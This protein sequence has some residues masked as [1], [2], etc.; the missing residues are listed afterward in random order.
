MTVRL[1]WFVEKYCEIDEAYGQTISSVVEGAMQPGVLEEKTKHL[2]VLALDA[3]KGSTEGVRVV[4]R[5]A[6]QAGASDEEIM[7][8]LRLAYFVS[9]MDTVKTFLVAF[10]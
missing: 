5:Q 1:P 3:L 6:R 4:A 9:G 2:V 7:E 10:E 8:V